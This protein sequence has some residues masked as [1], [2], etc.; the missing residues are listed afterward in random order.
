[1]PPVTDVFLS[2]NWGEDGSGRD[3]HRH[4]SFINQEL[5]N[6]GYK[7]WFHED[8]MAGNIPERMSKG[9]SKPRP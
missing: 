6:M 3:N 4:V 2:H 8:E 7:T 9:I 5:K 1:M